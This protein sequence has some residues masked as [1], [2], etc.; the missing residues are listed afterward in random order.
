M[1]EY[2]RAYVPGG[3]FFF[4]VK[5]FK[6]RP[7]LTEEPYR[8]TLR[9]AIKDVRKR[10]PFQ[11]IAWVLLPDHLH[12]VWKLPETDANF[13]LRWSLIKQHVTRQCAER[14]LDAPIS[15]SRQRRGEGGIWQRQFWEH[16]IRDDTDLRNHIDYIHYNPV[17][18][19][20]VTQ[21]GDWP[22][23]TFH[24]YVRDGVYPKNWAS[25]DEGAMS[26]YGE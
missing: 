15:R 22:F 13:S 12:T 17:K 1:S 5:T 3:T 20:Y 18:H 24:G 9:L 16:L 11:S 6:R 26:N 25:A 21:P 4:T 7:I 10:L 23:S 8:A 2:R 19:G 14:T